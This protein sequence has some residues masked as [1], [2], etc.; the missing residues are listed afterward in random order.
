MP[1]L[2]Y[3]NYFEAIIL[4]LLQGLTEFLPVSSSGH[5]VIAEHLLGLK[6]QGV[7]FE[8]LVH[9]GTL[10]S[11]LI[12]FRARIFAMIRA[13][14]DKSMVSERKMILFI[15][16]GTIPAVIAGLA[17]ED[18][19]EQAFSAPVMTAVMLIVT[20]LILLSTIAVRKKDGEMTILRSIIIGIGQAIAILPGISR[21]GSTISFGMISGI[22]PVVAAEYSFLLSIPA[23]AGAIV[24]K[25]RELAEIQASMA[26]QYLVG[27]IVSFL[28]GLFAVYLLLDIIKRGKFEYFGIYCLLVGA[29]AL[30]YFIR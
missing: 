30:I 11:V 8:L 27:T 23:I 17:F 3:M 7:V 5:L 10:L 13:V 21:S 25:S 18:F 4:G 6:Q 20:G 28:S 19:F 22:K 16:V 12:Y 29:A 26:G 15:I 2:F 14:F 24:L 9:F 1:K